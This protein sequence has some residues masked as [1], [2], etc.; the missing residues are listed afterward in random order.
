MGHRPSIHEDA[1]L[2]LPESI[3]QGFIGQIRPVRPSVFYLVGL[4]LTATLM[5]LLP[6]AYM[7]IVA[8]VG[9][10]IYWHVTSHAGWISSGPSGFNA[11]RFKLI[12]FIGPIVGGL[13]LLFFMI[14]PLLARGVEEDDPLSL[15]RGQEPRLF[16]FVDAICEAIRAP[17]PSRIDIDCQV[18]AAAHFRK[19]LSSFFRNDLVLLLGLPLVAGMNSAQLAGV[20][21]HE[22]GHFSQ[23]VAM[24]LT[25][26]IRVI[27]A[28]LY[29]IAC[30]R[31][32]WDG[33]IKETAGDEEGYV[34]VRVVAAMSIVLVWLTR[35]F[36]RLLALIGE[37][38]SCFMSRQMEYNADRFEAALVGAEVFEATC[39]RL[40]QLDVACYLAERDLSSAWKERRLANNLPLMIARKAV[41]LTPAALEKLKANSLRRRTRL[42]DTHPSDDARIRN[43]RRRSPD[44]VYVGT[45][46]ATAA[47]TNF[48][49]VAHAVTVSH[50]RGVFGLTMGAE[51]LTE[52][53][54]LIAD[55]RR[56]RHEEGRAHEYFSPGISTA[57]LFFPGMNRIPE[58]KDARQTAKR[59]L[60]SK[61]KLRLEQPRIQKVLKRIDAADDRIDT[62]NIADAL[63]RGN[64]KIKPREFN[65]ARADASCAQEAARLAEQE[66]HSLAK[67]L[68]SIQSLRR[69]RLAAALTLLH[70]SAIRQAAGPQDPIKSA[71]LVLDSLERLRSVHSRWQELGRI[72]PVLYAASRMDINESDMRDHL[73]KLAGILKS[74]CEKAGYCLDDIRAAIKDTPL[75]ASR[76]S[77][78]LSLADVAFDGADR[79]ARSIATVTRNCEVVYNNL[80]QLYYR[81]VT[82]LAGIATNVEVTVSKLK[83]KDERATPTGSQT[84]SDETR[85]PEQ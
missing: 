43:V 48:K 72:L 67:P 12:G 50:Y 30:V 42:F 81:L 63:I 47:F 23:R 61:E 84:S 52:T 38:I 31:D 82:Q 59:L 39:H 45:G 46:P 83:K 49:M 51:N 54:E 8:G 75:P 41:E 66:M 4:F 2:Q 25:Y 22:L 80:L 37:L 57:T 33:F 11:V 28:W 24:R 18:N 26:L 74:Q 3:V 7:A 6:I 10:A 71:N 65:I 53:D 14:K 44:P 73:P 55:S 40:K 77:A 32:E 68:E 1:G 27:N 85:S 17:K 64:V 29:R 78:Q 34:A 36:L 56:S 58:L 9:Y 19:G 70:V 20:I 35:L 21:A 62:A 76:S 60:L 69:T 5:V 79:N 13:V 15:D 16:A